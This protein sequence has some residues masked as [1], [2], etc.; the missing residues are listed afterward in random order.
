MDVDVE[1][2][3]AAFAARAGDLGG[4]V[5][6]LVG[7]DAARLVTGFAGLAAFGAGI[8]EDA[9]TAFEVPAGVDDV[10][11]LRRPFWTGP[12]VAKSSAF[13][14]PLP[15]LFD[16]VA[17][18]GPDKRPLRSVAARLVARLPVEPDSS[19]VAC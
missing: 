7:V 9:S 5:D 19:P 17:I 8:L 11:L 12:G 15:L 14:L 6:L 10:L 18:V 16:S 1:A 3:M 4:L 13:A 2:G